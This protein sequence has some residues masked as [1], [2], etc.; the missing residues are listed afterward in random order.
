MPGQ[1]NETGTLVS[2]WVHL[3]EIVVIWGIHQSRPMVCLGD[4]PHPVLLACRSP[5]ASI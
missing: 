1:V 4:L 3:C 2:D 5:T